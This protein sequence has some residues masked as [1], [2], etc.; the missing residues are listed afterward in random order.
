LLYDFFTALA[1]AGNPI[2]PDKAAL[3]VVMQFEPP[4]IGAINRPSD[5][6]GQVDIRGGNDQL[7]RELFNADDAMERMPVRSSSSW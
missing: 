4:F 1:V 7:V 6:F 3:L 2:D 5:A